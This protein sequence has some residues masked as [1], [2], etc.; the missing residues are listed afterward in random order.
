MHCCD[1]LRN[2]HTSESCKGSRCC[3]TPRMALFIDFIYIKHKSG[4]RG[5]AQRV[6]ALDMKARRPDLDP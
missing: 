1:T 6:M 4:S 2:V 3:A 5:M